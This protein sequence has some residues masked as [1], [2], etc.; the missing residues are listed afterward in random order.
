MGAQYINGK[1]VSA[2]CRLHFRIKRSA[3]WELRPL[4]SGLGQ[5]PLVP[6]FPIMSLGRSR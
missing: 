2:R 6:N 1:F 5:V 4:F 3:A